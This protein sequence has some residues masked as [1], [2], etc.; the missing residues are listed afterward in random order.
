MIK[1]NP[2]K[3]PVCGNPKVVELYK[4][5]SRAVVQ[6]LLNTD[7]FTVI[8]EYKK[9]IEKLWG[10]KNA[11]FYGC[12]E[13]DFEFAHPFIAADADFYSFVYHSE[14]YYPAEKWEYS[15]TLRSINRFCKEATDPPR[16]LELG[17]G[18]GSFLRMVTDTMIPA[19]EV[20]A[21]EFSEAGAKSIGKMGIACFQKDLQQISEKDL[22][23]KIN[24]VCMFQVLEH[25]TEIHEFFVKISTLTIS[26]SRLYISVPNNFHRSFFDRHGHH[27]DL[28][29]VHVGRYNHKS[30]NRLSEFHGWK[31]LQYL[32]QPSSYKERVRKFIFSAYAKGQLV[33]NPEKNKVKF[34]RLFLRYCMLAFL[35]ILH[36]R[37]IV[38]LRNPNLGTAQWFELEK[39]KID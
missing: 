16:L 4:T 3:C 38:G 2:A 31:I 17:A 34:I 33:F 14:N 20:F 18:N 24:I 11:S 19:N 37:I 1:D 15:V 32:L 36:T 10:A 12:R 21:T 6:H 26:G 28:P 22:L 5:D 8:E 30:L 35:M 23:G 39:I 25:M 27:Y 29:P 9:K 7:N 13:C